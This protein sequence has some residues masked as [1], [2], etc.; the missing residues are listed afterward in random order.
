MHGFLTMDIILEKQKIK[1][2]IGAGERGRTK[3][4]EHTHAGNDGENQE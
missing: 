1:Q 4:S 3:N 2:D